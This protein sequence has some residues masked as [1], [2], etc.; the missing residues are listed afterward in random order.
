MNAATKKT[1]IGI[2]TELRDTKVVGAGVKRSLTATIKKIDSGDIRDMFGVAAALNATADRPLTVPQDAD[3]LR[4]VALTAGKGTKPVQ[5]PVKATKATA[6]GSGKGTARKTAVKAV[7]T[8]PAGTVTV[9]AGGRA[10]SPRKVKRMI[11]DADVF[12]TVI[13]L[14]AFNN[15]KHRLDDDPTNGVTLVIDHNGWI[16]KVWS[17]D[18]NANGEGWV[19][20]YVELAGSDD[21]TYAEPMLATADDVNAWLADD[22]GLKRPRGKRAAAPVPTATR[23]QA[24]AHD[25]TVSTM[26]NAARVAM[27]TARNMAEGSPEPHDPATMA[28]FQS[29]IDAQ[30]QLRRIMDGDK[31]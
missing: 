26:V 22:L 3:T 7:Q 31:K 2:L 11:S 4:S 15:V 23:R 28:L 18:G 6:A 27:E 30:V 16:Y 19:I 12:R 5:T 14:L 17:P 21:L 20:G 9:R 13:D 24:T 1:T 10:P 8:G 25:K 29:I